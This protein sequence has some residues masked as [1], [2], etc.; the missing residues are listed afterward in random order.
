MFYF[1]PKLNAWYIDAI[2][3]CGEEI[4]RKWVDSGQK[5][6]YGYAIMPRSFWQNSALLA[7]KDIDYCFIG[8]FSTDEKT[9]IAR[10]WLLRFI[11][12]KFDSKCYLQFTDRTTRAGYIEKGEYDHTLRRKGF[13]PKE[14]PIEQRNWFDENYFTTMA[15]S[16]FV[17]CPAGDAPWSMRFL[18][19]IMCRA[20]PVVE[21]P[22]H[23]YRSEQEALLGYKFYLSNEQHEYRQDWVEHNYA[24]FLKHHTFS[25][26]LPE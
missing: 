18:E 8:A 21:S 3:E 14:L 1:S 13:V 6:D 2:Q 4:Y 16:K 22:E 23:T 5:I 20:L 10:Q 24:I 7:T 19:A 12:E 9:H 25:T 26:K 15:R 11:E 17:L